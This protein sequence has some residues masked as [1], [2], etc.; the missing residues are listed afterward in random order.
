MCRV[1]LP[2]SVFRWIHCW[3]LSFRVSRIA[4]QFKLV[5]R[6]AFRLRR[7]AIQVQLVLGTVA[8]A[9]Q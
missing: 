5:P 8:V 3:K 7:R 2:P 6:C 9:T 4:L 1:G